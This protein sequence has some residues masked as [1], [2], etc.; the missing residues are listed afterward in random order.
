M[1]TKTAVC[2]LLLAGGLS[3]ETVWSQAKRRPSVRLELAHAAVSRPLPAA[4]EKPRPASTATVA[5]SY[6]LRTPAP[7]PAAEGLRVHRLVPLYTWERTP[8]SR[9]VRVPVA[10][11]WDGRL[12]LACF[13]QRTRN[14]HL[15]A[16]IPTHSR[17]AYGVGVWFRID[18]GGAIERAP[19]GGREGL[20]P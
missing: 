14:A 8:F 13:H 10:D 6:I 9:Q 19:A 2:V 12:Q 7:A 20:K 18:R 4:P 11:L 16:A 1:Q 5:P 3:Q 15:N 17:A